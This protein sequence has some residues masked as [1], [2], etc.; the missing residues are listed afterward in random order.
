M[1]P[2]AAEKRNELLKELPDWEIVDEHHLRKT[3][4]FPDF[5]SALN[6][7]NNVGRVAE[8]EDHHPDIYLSW[9]KVRLEIW[10]HKI[11]NLTESDFILA[12][13]LE[14]LMR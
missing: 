1:P 12:A 2:L 4:K 13:K 7:V 5:L 11:N 10:T 8:D 9:G 6:Y 14:D 3:F